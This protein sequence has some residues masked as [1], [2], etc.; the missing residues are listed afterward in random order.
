M[1]RLTMGFSY[2]SLCVK[3][4]GIGKLENIALFAEEILTVLKGA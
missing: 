2:F 3:I 1:S 4:L